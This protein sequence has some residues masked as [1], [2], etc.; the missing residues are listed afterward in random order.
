MDGLNAGVH[1][2]SCDGRQVPVRIRRDLPPSTLRPGS[3]SVGARA[4]PT[5]HG[6]VITP[7]LS[8]GARL[9]AEIYYWTVTAR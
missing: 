5:L 9:E 1:H 8:K 4:L 2:R 7:P 6:E 3:V